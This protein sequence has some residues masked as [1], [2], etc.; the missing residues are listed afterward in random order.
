MELKGQEARTDLVEYDPATEAVA[1]AD[2]AADRRRAERAAY[3]PDGLAER[4]QTDDEQQD[5]QL[6]SGR[7][8]GV[9][10]PSEPY[11]RRAACVGSWKWPPQTPHTPRR[12]ALA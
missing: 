1:E 5:N 6:Q 3:L 12:W 2:A 11:G 8:D 4:E 10:R 9:C 7:A